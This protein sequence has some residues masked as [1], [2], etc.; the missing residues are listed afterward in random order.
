MREVMNGWK[1]RWPVVGDVRGLGPMMLAEFV[2]D[3]DTKEPSTPDQTL[4]IV[5]QAVANGVVVMRAGLYSNGI[6]L[7]PPL[8]MPE[9]MLREGLTAIG[10]AIETVSPRLVA[11]SV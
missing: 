4:L 11:A 10:S 7:L 8:T 2:R 9:D 6:R 5:R 3:R 1:A